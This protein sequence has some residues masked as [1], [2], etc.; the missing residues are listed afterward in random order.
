MW[1]PWGQGWKPLG[2]A[3]S[4][5]V[6]GT[7]KCSIILGKPI[8]CWAESHSTALT[9]YRVSL[10]HQWQ[11]DTNRELLIVH[12]HFLP[13]FPVPLCFPHFQLIDSVAIFSLYLKLSYCVCFSFLAVSNPI[14]KVA[15]ND[16]NW[17][18]EQVEVEGKRWPPFG[19]EG[20]Q[21]GS[22]ADHWN[23]L[24][25]SFC[26][27]LGS[28]SLLSRMCMGKG[29]ASFINKKSQWSILG[30]DT[31]KIWTVASLDRKTDE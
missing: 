31:R 10:Y 17:T 6:L 23:L 15:E 19:G 27:A 26:L 24:S 29:N 3:V 8:T 11:Q 5:T 22:P 12:Y 7:R 14:W 30:D 2:I 13:N 1:A 9:Q 21:G 18:N 4:R 16:H 25:S 20:T 28:P